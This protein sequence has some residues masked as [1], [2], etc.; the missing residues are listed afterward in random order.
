M[1]YSA[2]WMSMVGYYQ[3]LTGI[4]HAN[5]MYVYAWFLC[6]ISPPA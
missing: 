2:W 4:R 3:K 5:Q 6:V 1:Y